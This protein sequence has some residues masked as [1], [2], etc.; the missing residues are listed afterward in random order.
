VIAAAIV[1]LEWVRLVLAF[2]LLEWL[3]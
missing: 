3:S 1:L 2:K